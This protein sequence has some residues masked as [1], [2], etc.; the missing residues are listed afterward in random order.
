MIQTMQHHLDALQSIR[1][2]H[3]IDD[4]NI[5]PT[6]NQLMDKRFLNYPGS[7]SVI[8]DTDGHVE[9][10]L[11]AEKIVEEV[12]LASLQGAERHVSH[13]RPCRGTCSR[14]ISTVSS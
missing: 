8:S 4:R 6:F 2:K 7:L 13:S 1:S 12:V 9:Q 10:L 5:V 14:R 11:F 3:A